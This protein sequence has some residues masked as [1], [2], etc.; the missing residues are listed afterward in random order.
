VFLRSSFMFYIASDINCYL[1]VFLVSHSF[2]ELPQKQRGRRRP[3]RSASESPAL[4]RKSFPDAH[5]LAFFLFA[6]MTNGISMAGRPNMVLEFWGD[7]PN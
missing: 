6:R 4:P 2:S 3:S 7:L 5:S 1:Y